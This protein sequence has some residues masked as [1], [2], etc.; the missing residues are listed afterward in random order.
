MM[1]E[2]TGLLNSPGIAIIEPHDM[3]SVN[4]LALASIPKLPQDTR[5]QRENK[6][7]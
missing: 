4:E 6:R 1:N 2:P 3:D 7:I 5:L